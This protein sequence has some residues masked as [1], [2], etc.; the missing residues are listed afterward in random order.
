MKKQLLYLIVLLLNVNHLSSQVPHIQT[1]NHLTL[2]DW[3]FKKGIYNGAEKSEYNAADWATIKVPHTYSMDA[4]NGLGYYRGQAW[5]RTMITVPE[6]MKGERLFLRFEGV[7][8]EVEIFI[9]GK[10]TGK[11]VGGYSAFCFD[12]TDALNEQNNLIALKVSNKPNFR[13]IPVNDELFNQYGGVYRPVHLFSTPQAHID[14]NYYASPG[15]FVETKKLTAQLAE[16][17]VRVH[18]NNTSANSEAEISYTILDEKGNKV[19]SKKQELELENKLTVAEQVSIENPRRWNGRKDPHL[20]TL[21]VLLK[22][23]TST[24]T[25]TQKFGI[26]NFAVDPNQGFMLNENNYPLYGV[27]MH[28][29]WQQVG[30]A[31]TKEHHQTDLALIDEIGATAL[32]LSHYQHS[33]ISYVLSDEIGLVLWSEIP[34]V[35]N[36]SG[37]EG[38]NAKQQLN[39]LIL[40]NY[41]H[42]SICFWGLWNEV[43]SWAGKETPAV[44]LTEGLQKLAKE[45]DP[46]RLTTS[47]SDKKMDS[48]MSRISDLQS[49]NKYYGWY[50]GAA[51]YLGTWLDETHKAFPDDPLCV[52]EYGAGGNLLHQDIKKLE[53][54][55]G[56]YFAEQF[57][58]EYHET[59]W[60]LLKDRPFVW[61]SFVWNMFDFSVA[62]W[63]RGGTPN[64]NHKGLITYDRKTK[65]DAFY[66]YKANWSADPVL[67]LAERRHTHRTQ[68][69]ATIKV[70]TNLPKVTLYVNEKKIATK[71]LTSDLA[72][73][74]FSEVIL[75]EGKNKIEVRN[76]ET[77]LT[78]VVYWEIQSD[79]K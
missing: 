24:D 41:N 32:R 37:R 71:S 75:K 31:L 46:T 54:P 42:P 26:R 11:H 47:A 69:E 5:Y 68:R 74:K 29:E 1:R 58:T 38:G 14:P 73:I 67:Y 43:R 9:N 25:V 7:G 49:F 72:T 16:L 48:P 61:G 27:A 13:R 40:Q 12:V 30:P 64:L 10:K 56:A 70:F 79:K 50:G 36:W 52:S 59:S 60:K 18:I 55:K 4:I 34:Y 77:G 53:K 76:E 3:T 22:T 63:N 51:D 39:E 6:S 57:Q 17:E 19:W 33:D 65:K 45:L 21:Q 44:K 20:Y 23:K 28:E 2:S 62:G 8:H 66:F 78:D 15:V 35:H